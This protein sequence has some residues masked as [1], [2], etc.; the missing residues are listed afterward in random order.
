MLFVTAFVANLNTALPSI[1]TYQRLSFSSGSSLNAFEH[2]TYPCVRISQSSPFAPSSSFNIPSSS[3]F[4]TYAPPE[5]SPN[6]TQ[7]DLSFQ[8]T[9]FESVSAPMTMAFSYIP[10]FM[11]LSAM[12]NANINPLHAAFTSNATAF[13]APISF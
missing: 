1:F 11:Y 13:T 10:V 5:P 2:P 12:L 3:D 9:I 4:S 8:S 6:N 7:V